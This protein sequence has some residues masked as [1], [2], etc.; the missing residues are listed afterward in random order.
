[1]ARAKT[2]KTIS[3]T[4]ITKQTTSNQPD[5]EKVVNNALK[6][7]ILNNGIGIVFKLPLCFRSNVFVIAQFIYE[8]KNYEIKYPVFHRFFQKSSETGIFNTVHEFA[9]LLF[10]VLISLQFYIYISF[11]KRI[12]EL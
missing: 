5:P 3:N 1:M 10:T 4:A 2:M 12:Y 6:M 8:V 11:D 9:E 7:I